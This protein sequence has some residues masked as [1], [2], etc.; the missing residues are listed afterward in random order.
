[1]PGSALGFVSF[2]LRFVVHRDTDKT[3][4]VPRHFPTVPES[5]PALDDLIER[6]GDSVGRRVY[7]GRKREA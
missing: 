2:L 6:Y 4:P 7:D 3:I 5:D 1:M